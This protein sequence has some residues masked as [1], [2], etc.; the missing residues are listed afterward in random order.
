MQTDFI[1]C[2]MLYAIAIGHIIET[3]TLYRCITLWTSM[4]HLDVMHVVFASDSIDMC[5]YVLA[6]REHLMRQLFH[7]CVFVQVRAFTERAFYKTVVSYVRLC[8]VNDSRRQI[9]C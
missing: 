8:T 3:A 4:V 6:L 2:P 9:I 5:K 1:I 7:T